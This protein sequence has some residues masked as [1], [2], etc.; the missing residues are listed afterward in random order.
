ME[1]YISKSGERFGPYGLVEVQAGLDAGNIQATDLAWHEGLTGWCQVTQIR[2]I[3]PPAQRV[4]PPPRKFEQSTPTTAYK[5][6]TTI[7]VA[8]YVCA[9][10]SILFCP[11]GFGIAGLVLGVL[12]LT[13][14]HTGH[15]IA[16]IVISVTLGFI[17]LCLGVAL[18][19]L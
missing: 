8:G 3:I 10:V 7:I 17:G 15:G 4:P 2:G 13:R 5:S 19:S 11:P 9:C 1:I 16:I 6:N 14:G 18:S 12:A